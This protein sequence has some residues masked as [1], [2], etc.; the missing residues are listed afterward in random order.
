MVRPDA[1]LEHA[2]GDERVLTGADLLETSLE[3]F[4]TLLHERIEKFRPPAPPAV[5]E[6]V[7]SVPVAPPAQP[8]APLAKPQKRKPP[9]VLERHRLRPVLGWE[10]PS[11]GGSSSL[12]SKHDP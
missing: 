3:D 2:R 6:P 8:E 11:H 10:E 7:A 4:R 1:V 5:E 9:L 12:K